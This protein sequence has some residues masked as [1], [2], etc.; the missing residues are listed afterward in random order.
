MTNLRRLLSAVL[1]TLATTA[2]MAQNYDSQRAKE[3][4]YADDY[5]TVI[6]ILEPAYEKGQTDAY[7]NIT[8]ATSSTWPVN[9][10]AP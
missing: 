8:S 9:T 3:A 7:D 1:L 10:S 2:A 4:F 5:A 6:K